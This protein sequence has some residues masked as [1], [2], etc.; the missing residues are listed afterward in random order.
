MSMKIKFGENKR[1]YAEFGGF[2]IETDQSVKGGG[3]GSA[4]EPYTFFL[5][6][7][8]TCAGFYVLSFCQSR[9]ISTAGIE[10]EQKVIYDPQKK[11]IGTIRLDINVPDTFPDKYLGSL[12][13][14]AS[15]CSVKKT[16]DNPPEF[17]I[18]AKVYE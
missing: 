13:K 14:A 3:D 12:I 15:L 10:L 1:V 8:G 4:P 18:R 6:S 9:G 17:D 7:L 16:I 11:R 5:A 2:T